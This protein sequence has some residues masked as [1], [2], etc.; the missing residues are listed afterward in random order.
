M[1]Q[2]ITGITALR[3]APM[4]QNSTHAGILEAADLSTI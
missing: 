1:T 2:L 3:N 4:A